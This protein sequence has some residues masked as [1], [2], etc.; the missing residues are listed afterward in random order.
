MAPRPELYDLSRDPGELTNLADADPA[1]ARAL[2]SGLERHLAEAGGAAPTKSAAADVPPVCSKNSAPSATST[3]AAAPGRASAG[4]DPKD[5]VQD[6]KILNSLLHEGLIT[7]REKDY[8]ASAERFRELARRG[9]DSFESHYYFGQALVGLRRWPRGRHAVRACDPAAARIRRLVPRAGRMP[10]GWRR[11]ERLDRGA[12]GGS[13][14][15]TVRPAAV[16]ARRRHVATARQPGRSDS[17]LYDRVAVCGEGSGGPRAAGWS[18]PR[19]RRLQSAEKYF[20]D[21]IALDSGDAVTGTP[22]E[23]F[24]ARAAIWRRRSVCFARR[25]SATRASPVHL[26]P[27]AHLTARRPRRR[28]GPLLSQNA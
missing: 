14:R 22:S 4:I 7:L 18:A 12:S 17:R 11:S 23:W 9:I 10:H 8:A 5:K 13:T 2:R 19:C 15:R 21:A 26:Q 24:W 16:R 25:F 6:Y 28:R 1:R 3:P 27:R 20:R